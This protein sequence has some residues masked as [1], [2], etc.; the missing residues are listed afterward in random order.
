MP[1]PKNP[2][3]GLLMSMAMR[4]DHGL[5]CPGYYD[6][7]VFA[8]SGVTHAQRLERT[9][10]TM[11]Q[12]Y[13]EVSGHG[14]YKPARESEYAS[15]TPP[16]PSV[17]EVVDCTQEEVFFPLGVFLTLEAAIAACRVD[18]PD[19]FGCG[20][21]DDWEESVRWE[22]RER[23]LGAS[24]HGKPVYHISWSFSFDA[25]DEKLWSRRESPQS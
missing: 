11:Y 18:S 3:P 16:Q 2:P 7:P 9:L 5:G 20:D 24:G 1:L 8:S 23:L 14:F 4:F 21:H 22:I 12:L 25:D 15:A 6:Q 19:A 17:F 13:E 10:A